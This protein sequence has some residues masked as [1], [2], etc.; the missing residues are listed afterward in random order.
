ML[1][2]IIAQAGWVFVGNCERVNDQIVVSNCRNIRN[3][4]A[5][6]GLGQIARNGP[7]KETVLDDY[8]TMEI[9]VLAIVGTLECDVKAW[10]NK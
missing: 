3:W 10:E 7:T 4:G 6:T 1:K 2:I 8:G 5:K 9:H